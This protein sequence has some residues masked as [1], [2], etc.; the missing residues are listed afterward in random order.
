[1]ASIVLCLHNVYEY[2]NVTFHEAPR[3]FWFEDLKL[4]MP[5]DSI[6]ADL[7]AAALSVLKGE[8][9][10]RKR[11]ATNVTKDITASTRFPKA[12][13]KH[14]VDTGVKEI[15]IDQDDERLRL[16]KRTLEAKSKL[17]DKLE[18]G[19]CV[20]GRRDKRAPLRG[21][22]IEYVDQLGRTRNCTRD[23]FER[24]DG[25]NAPQSI[26]VNEDEDIKREY[27]DAA[28]MLDVEEEHRNRLRLKWA[29]EM[30][31]LSSLRDVHYEHIR[32][33]EVRELGV[34]YFAFSQDEEERGTQLKRFKEL[35]EETVRQREL[36]VLE[37]IRSKAKMDERLNRI[38]RNRGLVVQCNTIEQVVKCCI[39]E[40]LHG[41]EKI[42]S[43]RSE[44]KIRVADEIVQRT[45]IQ[46]N[47][48]FVM[49]REEAYKSKLRSERMHEFGPYY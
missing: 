22:Y 23:E 46:A 20:E 32:N 40:L 49:S 42:L 10:S 36:S 18:S 45:Q 11:G 9:L 19:E 8:I 35:R 2:T 43:I 39:S 4:K 48:P 28:E 14:N 1:M 27:R 37:Q 29:Q 33:D 3:I 7:C 41:V 13:K 38:R 44:A 15:P 47:N 24:L 16:S 12:I 31:K 30:E 34:G 5:E 26:Y 17:Y 6:D 25:L 21:N